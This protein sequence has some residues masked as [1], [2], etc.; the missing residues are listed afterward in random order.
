M[1][2]NESV[3]KPMMKADFLNLKYASITELDNTSSN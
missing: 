3:M 2:I 1:Q